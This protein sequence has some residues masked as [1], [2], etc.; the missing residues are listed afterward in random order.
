[1]TGNNGHTFVEAVTSPL[2][3]AEV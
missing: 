1:M 3:I 2:G